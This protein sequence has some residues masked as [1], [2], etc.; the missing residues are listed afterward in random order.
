MARQARGTVVAAPRGLSAGYVVTGTERSFTNAAIGIAVSMASVLW[1]ATRSTEASQLG[2]AAFWSGL[3]ALMAVE[4]TGEL[5]SVGYGVMG[6]NA[7]FLA[8]RLFHPNL[9][10]TPGQ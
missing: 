1:T 8:L 2:W 6:A 10:G 4:G 9:A 3:G 7:S 5:Q